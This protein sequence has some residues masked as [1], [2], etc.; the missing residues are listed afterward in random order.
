MCKK[1]IGGGGAALVCRE[2]CAYPQPRRDD[3]L[4]LPASSPSLTESERLPLI[5][6]WALVGELDSEGFLGPSLSQS[7]FRNKSQDCD[8]NGSPN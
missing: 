1:S 8:N 6:L 2:G 5:T 4:L 3:V 7:K